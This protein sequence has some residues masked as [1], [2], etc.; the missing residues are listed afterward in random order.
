MATH[1]AAGRAQVR[2]LRSQKA[3]RRRASS[4]TTTGV[5]V[6]MMGVLATATIAVPI[7][8]AAG[9]NLSDAATEPQALGQE[10]TSAG[11]AR[12]NAATANRS[13]QRAA[14]PVAS[15]DD[16][17]KQ[18]T[19]DALPDVSIEKPKEAPAAALEAAQDAPKSSSSGYIHPVNAPITSGYGWRVHPTLGYRKLHDGIDFGASCG[20]PVRAAAAG[21]VIEAQ[22]S[23]ASGNRIKVD[24]GNG[25]ITGYFHLSAY[26]VR[27]GQ[28]VSQGQV[29]G[30]VGS[31]GRSTGCHLHFAKMNRDGQ[32]SNPIS[33]LR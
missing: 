8:S 21:K 10:A 28:Q 26:K 4:A 16:V 19:K 15:E 11:A 24:H 14:L 30:N 17:K 20:T 29:I 25:V 9:G 2:P 5:R 31:T 22:Y 7:A 18:F 3:R 6:S 32:Y 12:E 23:G 27:A 1:R 13:L 33:L